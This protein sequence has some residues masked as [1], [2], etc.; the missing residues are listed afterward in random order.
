MPDRRV[1]YVRQMLGAW[2]RDVVE[3]LG[4]RGITAYADPANAERNFARA[5]VRHELLPALER[6]RPGIGRP[7]Y[8]AAP[9]ASALQD[10]IEHEGDG[11][12]AA[13]RPSASEVAKRRA[14]V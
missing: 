14:P 10:A 3:F 7:F 1:E 5:R 13:A 9:R 8:A 4:Q 12:L 2:R 11:L 6:D